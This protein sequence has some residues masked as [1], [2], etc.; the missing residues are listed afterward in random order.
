M[1]RRD[2]HFD[3]PGERVD[4]G[5]GMIDEQPLPPPPRASERRA[6]VPEAV[7]PDDPLLTQPLGDL[8][9][10]H[11]ISEG[12]PDSTVSESPHDPAATGTRA[13]QPASSRTTPEV[14]TTPD[15]EPDVTQ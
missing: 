7:E 13:E 3:L 11:P 4:K 2:D 5:A 14:P 12:I 10:N 9:P 8:V 15:W 1:P 6:T